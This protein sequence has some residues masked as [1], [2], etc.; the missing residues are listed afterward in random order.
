M[1]AYNYEASIGKLIEQ[2]NR[3]VLQSLRIEQAGWRTSQQLR[4]LERRTMI[5]VAHAEEIGH[6][7]PRNHLSAA[8]G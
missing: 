6:H 5:A 1:D 4:E 7:R 3:L 8:A 2:S